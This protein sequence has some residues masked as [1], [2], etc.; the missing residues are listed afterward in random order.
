MWFRS[1]CRTFD[2]GKMAAVPFEMDLDRW[3]DCACDFSAQFDLGSAPRLAPDRS[4]PQRA[5]IQ[6]RA[7]KPLRISIR[8]DTFSSSVVFA[9]LDWWAWLAFLFKRREA[10]SFS[11]MGLFDCARDIHVARRKNVLRASCVPN[12]D[13]GRRCRI[14]AIRSFQKCRE[15]S[16]I[17]L[18]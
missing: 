17:C 4:G 10:V 6:K 7:G 12:A 5:A 1:Y 18:S 9:S 15:A 14:R 13:G 11:W 2:R 3:L 8:T 16:Q